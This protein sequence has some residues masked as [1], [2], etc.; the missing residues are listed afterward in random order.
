[1]YVLY[2]D[3]SGD[4]KN[5]AN[6]HFV[7]AGV[8]AFE[9]QIHFLTEAVDAI[10]NRHLPGLEPVPFH[11]SPMRKGKDFWR[12]VPL[13]MRLQM[14]ADI[15]NVLANSDPRGVV[16]FAVAVQKSA[17]CY[18]E[19][20]VQ[21][22]VEEICGRFNLFLARRHKHERDTQRGLIVFAEGRFDQRARTW[23]RTFRR[24]GTR[25]GWIRNFAEDLP[26]SASAND[27]RML[28]LADHVAH[29]VFLHFEQNDDSL[30][31]PIEKKFDRD[32]TS[33]HGLVLK[34][35]N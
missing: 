2:L 27:S 13:E 28:Q 35:G 11:A 33:I 4:E 16:L 8:A 20:A 12:K 9:R 10:Q 22:A 34:T 14:L 29:A 18:G 26:Y 6:R 3:E 32:G 17:R 15:G 21:L 23:V 19:P 7:L 31:G 30:L 24:Q 25:I 5:A 1:M